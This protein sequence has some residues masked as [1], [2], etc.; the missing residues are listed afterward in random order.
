MRL[1]TVVFVPAATVTVGRTETDIHTRVEENLTSV[2]S[3]YSV[4]V[5]AK[6]A[7]YSR[8]TVLC[9]SGLELCPVLVAFNCSLT[10]LFVLGGMSP[11][12][13]VR[14]LLYPSLIPRHSDGSFV[15]K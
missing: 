14:K 11:H 10:H 8:D 15:Q 2:Q 9:E 3:K 13:I 6:F 5:N 4:L 12:R 1:Y 7:E